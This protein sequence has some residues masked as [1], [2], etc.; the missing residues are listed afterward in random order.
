MLTE[1]KECKEESKM[2]YFLFFKIDVGLAKEKNV[3][4]NVCCYIDFE[5][6]LVFVAHEIFG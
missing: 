1:N 5:F 6:F 4:G 3:H 2:Y